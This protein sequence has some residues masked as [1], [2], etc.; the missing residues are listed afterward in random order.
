[1][2]FSSAA[3]TIEA[4]IVHRHVFDDGLV[5]GMSDDG[6][7]HLSDGG[8]VEERPVIPISAL[9]PDAKITKAVV[10]AAVIPHVRPPISGVPNISATIVAPVAGRP[11]QPDSRWEHPRTGDPVITD[12]TVAPVAWRPYVAGAW[13]ERLLVD[14]KNGWCDADG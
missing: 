6:P 8:V 3:P 2:G 11:E 5:V 9:V 13:T 4:D 10:D 14:G 7:V 12:V 1:L